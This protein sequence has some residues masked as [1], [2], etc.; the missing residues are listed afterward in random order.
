MIIIY[1]IIFF[2]VLELYQT[3]VLIQL[4]NFA[5]KNL[6]QCSVNIFSSENY[7]K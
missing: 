2:K 3:N 5:K 6:D 1:M 7:F 4:S